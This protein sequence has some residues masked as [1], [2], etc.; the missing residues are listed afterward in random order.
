MTD[1]KKRLTVA[2]Q[3]DR[4]DQIAAARARGISYTQL[5]RTYG[6][7]KQRVQQIHHE[8]RAENPTIRQQT[9]VAIVD[10]LLE[11]YAA[12]IEELALLSA[13]TQSDSVRVGAI[14]A[15]MAARNKTTDLLQEMGVLPRDLGQ[16]RVEMDARVTAKRVINILKQNKVPGEVRDALLLAMQN[17]EEAVIE[18]QVVE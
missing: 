6:L 17:E 11:G 9:A 5:A 16:I 7:S 14:N 10:D 12:D 1:K 2:E 4:N 3:A 18:A 15:R 8:Y 13:T